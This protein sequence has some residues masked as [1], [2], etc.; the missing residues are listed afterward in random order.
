LI[1]YH[2][3]FIVP[4]IFEAEAIEVFILIRPTSNSPDAAWVERRRGAGLRIRS[5]GQRPLNGSV[6]TVIRNWMMLNIEE[7]K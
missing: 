1:Y 2:I 3:I 5:S 6:L 7:R 4:R